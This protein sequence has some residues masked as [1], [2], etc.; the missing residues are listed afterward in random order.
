MRK[1][2]YEVKTLEEAKKLAVSDFGVKESDLTFTVVSEKKGFLGIGSKLTVEAEV[3]V[4]GISKGKEYLQTFLENNGVQGFVEK[5]VRGNYV[6]FNIEAGDFNGSL[7]GR[8]AKNLTALQ[9]LVGLVVNN[10]YEGEE[11]KTVFVDVGGYKKR[12]VKNI[13]NLAVKY[14]KQVARTKQRIK[15]DHLNAY[16][17]KIIHNKLSSWKDV[18]TYSV[19]EEPK[20]CLVIEPKRKSKK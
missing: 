10:Y 4:D 11:L 16:E 5:K 9:L 18:T 19:G 20:R 6:E 3:S 15:L 8:N 13:E 14:G 2:L 1:K 7:I 17:R 12:R